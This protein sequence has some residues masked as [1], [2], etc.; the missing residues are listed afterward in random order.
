MIN[1]I[2][3]RG[4]RKLFILV[5]EVKDFFN[6]NVEGLV[7]T[8]DGNNLNTKAEKTAKKIAVTYIPETDGLINQPYTPITKPKQIKPPKHQN[9]YAN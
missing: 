1:Q 6:E 9:P 8:C 5:L 4:V 3:I 7:E 2:V